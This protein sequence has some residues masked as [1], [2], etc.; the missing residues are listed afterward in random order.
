MVATYSKHCEKL[1]AYINAK[2]RVERKI[3]GQKSGG[4]CIQDIPACQSK[5]CSC[6]FTNV[7]VS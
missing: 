6:K 5:T 3:C 1:T 4:N 2:N 7:I